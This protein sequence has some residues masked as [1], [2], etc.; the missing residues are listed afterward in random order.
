MTPTPSIAL[1][2]IVSTPN[3][4]YMPVTTTVNNDYSPYIPDAP[5]AVGIT[6]SGN[7]F[8]GP[9]FSENFN[10]GYMSENGFFGTVSP[11]IGV[12]ADAGFSVSVFASWYVG[13]NNTPDF[14]AYLGNSATQTIGAGPFS[15]SQ[16]CDITF[17][18]EDNPQFGNNWQTGSV[19]LSIGIND[20]STVLNGSSQYQYSSG[21]IIE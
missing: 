19:G 21:G 9:G 3:G 10:I 1:A 6:F 17:D 20:I 11:G 2:G 7:A 8:A 18:N 15:V 4:N 13:D 12:G 5:D 14:N 16:S